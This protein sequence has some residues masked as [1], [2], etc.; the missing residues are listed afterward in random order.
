MPPMTS[1][2]RVPFNKPVVLPEIAQQLAAA[3][4][5]GPLS[6]NGIHGKK[7]EAA[8]S[9]MAGR[10]VRLTT[11][12]T[13]ALEM[14]AILS[15]LK[16][17][18]EIIVPSFTFVSTVNAF[19]LRGVTPRFADNDSYGNITPDEIERL[20]NKKTKAIMVV[21]YGGNSADMDLVAKVCRER[22]LALYEDAAQAIGAT[23][24]GRPLGAIGALG[25]YSFH[26]TKNVT[27]GEG[28]GLIIGEER[29]LERAEIV[30]EKG[31]DR[32]KF[33]QGIV[34]KYTWVD[35]G[36][37]YVLSELNAAYLFPQLEKVEEINKKRGEIWKRYERDLGKDFA[38][39]D[40]TIL[41]TPEYNRPNYH[42][43][44]TVFPNR[45]MRDRFIN[46]MRDRNITCPFHY[47]P[48]HNSPFGAKFALGGKPE[49]LSV[50]EKLSDCLVRMPLYYSMTDA[51]FDYVV[52]SAREC[53][54]R[55]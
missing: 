50:C 17:G 1:T 9:K 28:G 22:G 11:S 43:F 19:V 48:L 54:S 26:D 41:K 34:D 47:I 44:G 36:S 31:T 35:V 53:I 55:A 2:M 14:I 23:Y 6:G 32:T 18:D 15:D 52:M 29:Y 20:A 42:L 24:K 40:I 8:L 46:D 33:F 10:L 30:R 45:K 25:A 7:C 4:S 16:P 39:K 13:H 12:G 5:A 51:E 38:R 49:T 37:S 3:V 21:H 27:S